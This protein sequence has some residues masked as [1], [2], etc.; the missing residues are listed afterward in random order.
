MIDQAG[1]RFDNEAVGAAGVRRGIRSRW[2]LAL[3]ILVC[4]APVIAS[5]LAYYV[6]PPSER[7]NYGALIEPQRPVPAL[8]A[9]VVQR[10]ADPSEG[11]PVL[12]V[13]DADALL[14]AEG[15]GAFRGRWILV[16]VDE[17]ACERACAEKLFF[18]RQT[19]ISMGR[20]RGRMVRVLLVTDATPLPPAVLAAHPDMT[21][22]R[23]APGDLTPL[24]P[25]GPATR[26][27]DHLFLIDPL[28][29]LMMRF[30]TSP[31]PARVRKDLQKLLRASRIG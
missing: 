25:A 7:T 3:V 6:F 14:A 12:A 1:Q 30:P 20:E 15:L 23:V 31:D 21:V 10:G 17:G 16:G 29:N 8:R 26:L 11:S 19:H 9:T 24:F 5:Y 13:A 22:L 28:R 18:M 27:S 4:L 2:V